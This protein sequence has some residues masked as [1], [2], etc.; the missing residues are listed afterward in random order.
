MI[1]KERASARMIAVTTTIQETPLNLFNPTFIHF[2]LVSTRVKLH[3][4][5][6]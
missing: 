4:G 1:N 6:S 5:R 2:L 3:I